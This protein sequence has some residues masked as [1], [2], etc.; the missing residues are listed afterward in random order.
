MPR[1]SST[2]DQLQKNHLKITNFNSLLKYYLSKI[3]LH[4]ILTTTADCIVDKDTQGLN[5]AQL[6]SLFLYSFASEIV[7]ECFDNINVTD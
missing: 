4:E 7:P 6:Q 1:Q 5:A 2:W 3:L